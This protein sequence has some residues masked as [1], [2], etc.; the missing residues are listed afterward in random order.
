MIEPHHVAL[1]TVVWPFVRLCTINNLQTPR[2][3]CACHGFLT[4]V[5]VYRVAAMSGKMA[6]APDFKT[7]AAE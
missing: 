3:S 7:V 2:K 5:V 1:C 4:P 6:A